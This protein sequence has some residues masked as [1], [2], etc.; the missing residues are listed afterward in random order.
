MDFGNITKLVNMKN[1][2]KLT[3][4]VSDKVSNKISEKISNFTLKTT[5]TFFITLLL[6]FLLSGFIVQ[7]AWNYS[8]PALFDIREIDYWQSIAIV[9][10]AKILLR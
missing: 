5:I 8:L 1:I 7:H 6:V 4:T 10:L 2:E 9:I 3:N